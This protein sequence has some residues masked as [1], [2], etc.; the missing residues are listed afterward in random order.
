[1]GSS[2][3]EAFSAEL[4]HAYDKLEDEDNMTGN[5][6]DSIDW[7]SN[8]SLLWAL[9][10][11]LWSVS[12]VTILGCNVLILALSSPEAVNSLVS[13]SHA[14]VRH[15][16]WENTILSPDRWGRVNYS[17]ITFSLPWLQLKCICISLFCITFSHFWTFRERK[18]R[19]L[20]LP[21]W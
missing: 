20:L 19:W 6:S 17:R 2:E 11:R 21:L 15:K 18:N 12:W 5:V 16:G 14:S 9:N 8:T 3:V 4:R 13:P 1:M 10:C 7:I